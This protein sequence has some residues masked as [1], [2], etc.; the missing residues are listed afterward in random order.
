VLEQ[1]CPDGVYC[2]LKTPKNKKIIKAKIEA[3]ENY[4]T[5]QGYIYQIIYQKDKHGFQNFE[6]IS[7]E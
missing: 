1:V 5:E 4:C 6:N 7:F 3:G 2:F